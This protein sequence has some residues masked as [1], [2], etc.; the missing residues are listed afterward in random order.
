M[1]VGVSILQILLNIAAIAVNGL[2][3]FM[4]GWFVDRRLVRFRASSDGIIRA[5]LAASFFATGL[6]LFALFIFGSRIN[7]YGTA[8]MGGSGGAIAMLVAIILYRRRR[9]RPNSSQADV[10]RDTFS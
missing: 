6:W 10:L 7:L 8:L 3:I 9:T 5:T 1:K 4:I 2:A